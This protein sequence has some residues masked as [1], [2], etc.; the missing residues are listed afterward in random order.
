VIIAGVTFYLDWTLGWD[1]T[2]WWTG[3]AVAA[4]FA[5]N[6]AFTYWIWAMEKGMIFTGERNGATVRVPFQTPS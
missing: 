6:G 2:K 1:K 4:Y 3:I 5:L